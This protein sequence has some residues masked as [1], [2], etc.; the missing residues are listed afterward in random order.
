M[1]ARWAAAE[2]LYQTAGLNNARFKLYRGVRHEITPE[3]RMDI[4]ETFRTALGAP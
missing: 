1:L 3:I 2:R 4:V